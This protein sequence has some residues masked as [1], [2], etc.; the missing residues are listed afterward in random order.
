MTTPKHMI[1]PKFKHDCGTCRFLGR[2]D[3]V[4]CYIHP[5]EGID[6]VTLVARRSDDDTDYISCSYTPAQLKE[7]RVGVVIEPFRTMWRMND[8]R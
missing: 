1:R 7:L 5:M 6:M 4:D 3:G 2:L 8:D